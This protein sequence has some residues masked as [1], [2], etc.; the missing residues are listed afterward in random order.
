MPLNL[1]FWKVQFMGYQPID[2]QSLGSKKRKERKN[3]NKPP[4]DASLGRLGWQWFATKGWRP[5]KRA[6]KNVAPPQPYRLPFGRHSG[7]SCLA[8]AQASK[9]AD[10]RAG[11]ERRRSEQATDGRNPNCWKKEI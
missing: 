11:R 9:S 4:E 8:R 6:R 2:F 1:F 10:E 7:K 3:K 5:F